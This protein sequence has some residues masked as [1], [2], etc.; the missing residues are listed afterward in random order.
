[1][2]SYTGKITSA[3][4]ND[5]YVINDGVKKLLDPELS[6]NIYNHSP[7]GFNWGFLGSGPSQAALGILLDCLG[8]KAA[9]MYYQ[10]FKFD[11]VSTWGDSFCISGGEIKEWLKK[12]QS[13]S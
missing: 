8:Q 2:K 7:D 5:I 12:Q 11:K 13:S 10:Q 1:M 3:G 9:I 4:P 6:Q